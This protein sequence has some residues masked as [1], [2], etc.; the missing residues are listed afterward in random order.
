VVIGGVEDCAQWGFGWRDCVDSRWRF[1]L[2]IYVVVEVDVFYFILL[3]NR[4]IV[5]G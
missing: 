5:A 1:K 4:Y 3:S 2:L